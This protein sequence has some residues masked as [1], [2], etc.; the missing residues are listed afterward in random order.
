MSNPREP[1]TEPTI[2]RVEAAIMDAVAR[3]SAIEF[4]WPECHRKNCPHRHG[5]VDYAF[6]AMKVQIIE[7]VRNELR[8]E[9]TTRP[10]VSDGMDSDEQNAVW[11][12]AAL[13]NTYNVHHAGTFVRAAQL[14]VDAY[15]QLVVALNQD[16]AIRA[17]QWAHLRKYYA[18]GNQ[19]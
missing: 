9:T 16:D 10:D 8:Y 12:L 14:M 19:A 7:S 18:K 1:V 5:D 6:G 15:P 17:E 4:D 11:A 2:R 3:R 13:L